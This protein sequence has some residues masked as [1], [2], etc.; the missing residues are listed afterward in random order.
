MHVGYAPLF[1]NPENRLPD[2]EVY[3]QELRL[4]DLAEPLG[5]DSLWSVEH[6]FT[7]YTMCPDVLQFLAYMAGRTTRA[8]LGSMVVVLPWHDPVRVAEEVAMLDNL[9]GG[10]VI[11]GI[12]RGLGRVEYEGF[13]LDMNESRERFLEYAEIILTGL[14]RGYV[15]H[16]GK[17]IHQPRRDL[18]P[19]P[20]L[21][22]KG[23]TFAAA[24]SPDSMPIMA[25]LGV[26]LLVI[27]QKPWDDVARDFE[28]Y[29]R[30]WAEEYPGTAPPRPFMGAFIYV[31]SDAERAREMA[32]RY[33]GGYYHTVIKHYEMTSDH[34]TR[35]KGYEFYGNV[36]K[37]IGRHG[38]EGA[39]QSFANLMPWG[40]PDQVLRKL[41]QIRS[42][43]DMAGM[44]CH[45]SYAGMPY[46]LA[47]AN[48]RLFARE[49]L[50]EL[51]RWQTAPLSEPAPLA[52]V[53]TR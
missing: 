11:L 25:R 5:F 49:V 2:H 38:R 20:F 26:G 23:R 40:T 21:S 4:A 30:V 52:P 32:Q 19:A 45:F 18:R 16:E 37:Y 36:A 13:R 39:A 51:H 28:V 43:I 34:F 47:E 24:V 17:Y 1:Q 48:M 15:E 31:D 29:H 10:R 50:P 7:D 42:I 22:F 53:L 14:E 35:T 46:D 3:A 33:I 9:S 27:P 12:G 8:K 41:E 6:H 44:M